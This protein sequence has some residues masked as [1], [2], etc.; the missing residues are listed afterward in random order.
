MATL[1]VPV[2]FYEFTD[3]TGKATGWTKFSVLARE[4]AELKR[5]ILDHR[6]GRQR[7]QIYLVIERDDDGGTD[8]RGQ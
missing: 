7:I 8:G 6:E 4:A 3:R 1:R 2:L 5:W